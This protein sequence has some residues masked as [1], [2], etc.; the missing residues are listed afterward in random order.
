MK[1]IDILLAEDDQPVKNFLTKALVAA[2]FNVVATSNGLEAWEEFQKRSFS[3]VLT[4]LDM[5]VLRGEELI[6]KI[7]GLESPLS[8]LIVVLTSQNEPEHIIQIMKKGVFDYLIKPAEVSQI[9]LKM[10]HAA[11]SYDLSRMRYVLE[12]EKEL[13][14]Q[15]QLNWIKY[16]NEISNQDAKSFRDNIVTNMRHN[17]GQ[18]GGFG[19]L[20]ALLGLVQNEATADGNFYKIEKDIFELLKENVNMIDKTF[21]SLENISRISESSLD[22]EKLSAHDIYSQIKQTVNSTTE[23]SDIQ[24]NKIVFG[25]VRES[26]FGY[27][28][29]MNLEALK[30][31]ISEVILNAC[32]FSESAS[33][34]FFLFRIQ[35]KKFFISIVNEPKQNTEIIGVP[36]EYSNLV[37]E[38]FFRIN[39]FVFEKY[40]SLDIGLGLTMVKELVKKMNGDVSILNL[41]EF[42]DLDSNSIKVRLELEFP[43]LT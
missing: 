7:Q 11:K 25:D 30:K 10:N 24:S 8:P 43:I 14:L 5:P 35:D 29:L 20:M 17:L 1:N 38:P 26:Y 37:F 2:G 6:D 9:I 12:S 13:R 27:M 22:L 41:K 32:K 23:I 21:S 31:I 28:I 3:L 4:D 16:K 42:I 34:I 33:K 15:E 18:S 19:N 39:K 36:L 40:P